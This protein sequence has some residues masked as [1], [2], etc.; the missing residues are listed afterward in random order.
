[1]SYTEDV[2]LH[3]RIELCIQHLKLSVELKGEPKGVIE[4]RKHYSGYLKGFTNASKIRME[5]M[6]FVS[7]SSA[8]DFLLKLK[9]N[10]SQYEY[11]V[12]KFSN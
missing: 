5:L 10:I 3:E 9:S 1:Q 2:S 11:Q 4:F 8:L 7:Y 6:K 12:E